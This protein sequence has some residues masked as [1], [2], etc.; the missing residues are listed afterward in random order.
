MSGPPP[1]PP[2]GRAPGP[3]PPGG[4]A[5]GP[6]PPPPP[7]PRSLG[8]TP[9]P[10]PVPLARPA[11]MAAAAPRRS[12]LKPLH[13]S[14]VTKPL[15]GSLWE[16]L[17][18]PGESQRSVYILDYSA[19]NFDVSEF[20][21]LFSAVVPKKDTSK[22][23]GQRKSTG[24]KNERIH[25]V[26]LRRANNTEIMLTK[27]KVPLPDL[28]VAVLAMDESLLDADQVENLIKFCPTKE[29]MELLQ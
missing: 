12:N 23:E 16:E 1:P 28:M 2:G 5:P 11:R 4:R 3:P 24:L 26:D 21:T 19:P 14:K 13:W 20:E 7:R 25:L 17:Q 8:P 27:I 15:Q 18:R 9:P 6:P 10:A 29:E 22:G